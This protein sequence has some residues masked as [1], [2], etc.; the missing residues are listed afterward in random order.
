MLPRS[1]NSFWRVFFGI[2]WVF[3]KHRSS[4]LEEWDLS[5]CLFHKIFGGP[6]RADDFANEHPTPNASKTAEGVYDTAPLQ[7]FHDDS[8]LHWK[9]FFFRVWFWLKA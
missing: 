1:L 3:L 6:C 8:S 5:I 7:G 4:A 9:A 2:L